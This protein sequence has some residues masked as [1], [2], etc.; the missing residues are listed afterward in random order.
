MLNCGDSTSGVILWQL[1]LKGAIWG[2]P[3]VNGNHMYLVNKDGEGLV[4]RLPAG[5]EAVTNQAADSRAT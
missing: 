2:S 5:K 1:R 3:A 4:V